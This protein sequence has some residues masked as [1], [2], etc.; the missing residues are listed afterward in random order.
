M[1]RLD[2]PTTTERVIAHRQRLRAAGRVPLS[3]DIPAELLHC[4]DEIK[5]KRKASSRTPLIE[6]ALR[7][8]CRKVWFGRQFA[9][10][11][12]RFMLC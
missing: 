5:A 8:A 7:R 12:A 2:S 6:E 9:P 1:S 3:A 11:W 4:L 10:E